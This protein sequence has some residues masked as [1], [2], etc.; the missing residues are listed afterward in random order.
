MTKLEV[1]WWNGHGVSCM[2]ADGRKANAESSSDPSKVTCKKCRYNLIQ[3]KTRASDLERV[4]E[5][6]L[7][8]ANIRYEYERPPLFLDFYLPDLDIYIEVKAFHSDRI[9]HQTSKVSD[10]IV[11]QGVMAVEVLATLIREA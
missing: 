10:I 3:P 9:L 8:A 5:K 1:H 4:I 11:V 7:V 6:A 2:T